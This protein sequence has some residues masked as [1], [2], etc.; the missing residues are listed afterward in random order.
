MT[1]SA[2]R[3]IAGLSVAA[4]VP[5][6]A[7]GAGA[8]DRPGA[9]AGAASG[10]AKAR[11]ALASRRD[12]RPP[13][14]HVERR[15]RRTKPGLI[16]VGPKKVF[17]AKRRAGSQQGPMVVDDRGRVRWFKPLPAGRTAYDLRVQRF[18]GRPVITWWQGRAVKGS[19]KGVGMIYDTRYRPVAQVRPR[20]GAVADIHEFLLTD[21]RTALML[22]YRSGVRRDLRKIG[23][24]ANAKV[25]DGI[26]QEI[27]VRT[28]RVLFEW[29][30]LDH[31][32]VA[33][34]H[35]P[36]DKLYGDSW[37]YVHFNS[38]DVD[39]D[40]NLLVSARHSWAVYKIDRTTGRI[41]WRLGGRRSDFPLAK[42]LRFSWQHDARAEGQN[43]VRI[44][45]NAAASERVRKRSR[46]IWF[47]LDPAAKRARRIRQVEHPR[48][49]S[50]GTQANAQAL[51]DGHVFVGWGSQGHFSEF[52]RR[53]RML[54]DARVPRGYDSYRAYRAPW[55][56]TPAQPPS[57]AASRRGPTTTVWASW[58]GATEVRRWQVLAGS[59]R[60]R[61]SAVGRSAAWGGLETRV[62]VRSSARYVAV[63]ALDAK[64]RTL[65]V[66]PVRRVARAR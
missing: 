39:T 3:V 52:D 45:D 56:A 30:A 33:E 8:E 15:A 44:F 32:D 31:I 60:D 25:V 11:T 28:G 37:D 55:T 53:G 9:A 61:L 40:G 21:R 6:L 24:K 14:I 17:G 43:V 7:A 48:G 2:A 1:R 19:G 23:G 13:G 49:L 16:L 47:R 64:G 20:G 10:P 42:D 5:V 54:F 51:A 26:V 41:I 27:D 59:R 22:V 34:S 57:V 4:C 29:S 35:E 18:E 58:N 50:S 66:S 63:R 65:A 46:V 38:I 36:L 62:R 12:L